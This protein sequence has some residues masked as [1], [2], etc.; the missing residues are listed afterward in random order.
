MYSHENQALKK[1]SELLLL[2]CYE[3]VFFLH[4]LSTPWVCFIHIPFEILEAGKMYTVLQ[5]CRNTLVIKY[6]FHSIYADEADT[7]QREPLKCLSKKM[8]HHQEVLT[9][10]STHTIFLCIKWSSVL[11]I[12]SLPLG[13]RLSWSCAQEI[14]HKKK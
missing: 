11:F 7:A 1:E 12:S 14:S 13:S 8:L 6:L 2:P 3:A 4:K 10:V 5:I 9:Q